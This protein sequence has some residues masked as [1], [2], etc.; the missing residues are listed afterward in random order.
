MAPERSKNLRDGEWRWSEAKICEMGN[1]AGAKQKFVR[2]N[3]AGAEQEF[4]RQNL[5]DNTETK[6]DGN[7]PY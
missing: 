7:E 4:E 2:G 3:G 5:Q 6:G 1:G